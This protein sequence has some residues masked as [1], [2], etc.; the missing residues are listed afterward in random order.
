MSDLSRLPR[1]LSQTETI[2]YESRER[3]VEKDLTNQSGF[4]FDAEKGKGKG[5][6][7]K[8]AIKRGRNKAE[9]RKR[10]SELEQGCCF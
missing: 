5:K 7:W 9:E 1:R 3:E 2:R 10:A 8:G 4:E 6:K